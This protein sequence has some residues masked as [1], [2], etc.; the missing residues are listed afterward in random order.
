MSTR[1]L[2]PSHPADDGELMSV[3]EAARRIGISAR[4]AYEM[5]SAGDIPAIRI[6]RHWRISPVRLDYWMHGERIE[7][8]EEC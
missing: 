2:K 6:G 7:R 1:I 5:V 3:P 8:D 4:K